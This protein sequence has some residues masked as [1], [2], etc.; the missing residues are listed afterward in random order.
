[1]LGVDA[2][3]DD[4]GPPPRRRRVTIEPSGTHHDTMTASP[5]AVLPPIAW[6]H[7]LWMRDITVTTGLVDTYST[8]T[9]M[10]LLTSSRLNASRFVTHHLTFGRFMEAYDVFTQSGE[11]KALKVV[12][13][14]DG[15]A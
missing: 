6:F 1:V 15:A 7:E 13:T 8:P 11:T 3:A 2:A 5:A 4:R 14:P 9:L 12:L 10:R